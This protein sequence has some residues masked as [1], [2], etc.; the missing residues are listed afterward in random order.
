MVSAD[1]MARFSRSTKGPGF[2]GAIPIYYVFGEGS[3]T[4]IQNPFTV[5]QDLLLENV[6]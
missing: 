5:L 4:M 6:T 1:L 2:V 3:R